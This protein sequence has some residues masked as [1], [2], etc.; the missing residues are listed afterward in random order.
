[1]L[2]FIKGSNYDLM[3]YLILGCILALVLEA[4]S[5]SV[6]YGYPVFKFRPLL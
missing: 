4:V 1:M 3:V 2:A 6:L 5:V